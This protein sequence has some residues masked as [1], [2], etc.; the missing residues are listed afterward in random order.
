MKQSCRLRN[1]RL[2]AS[3]RSRSENSRQ[4]AIEKSRTSGCSI[5][6]NQPMNWVASRR[7]IRL[8]SRKLMSSCSNIRRICVSLHRHVSLL[9]SRAKPNSMA[10]AGTD[11][12]VLRARRCGARNVGREAAR[13]L[14]LS[15]AKHP[16]LAGH[17]PHGAA[18]RRL[19]PVLRIRRE[20]V[21]LRRRCARRD[22]G[23]PPR[24]LH[25]ALGAVPEALCRNDPPHCRGRRQHFRS[26]IHRRLS[27]A[28]PVQPHGA[29]ASAGG[30]V[31]A[32]LGR[33]HRHRSR[34]Q[35]CSTTSPA[36]TASTCSATTS[37]RTPWSAASRACATSARCSAPIIR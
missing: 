36:P 8:V 4:A 17:S 32:V 27:G 31:P 9:N 13:R 11:T 2:L 21:F 1:S 16:S 20:P 10:W 29:R 6:L 23:A 15:Q 19:R 34:R 26:A 28:V 22:R 33:R 5:R 12:G 3:L 37:T 18:A 25:A 30:V 7:G 14:E 24:R 35:S